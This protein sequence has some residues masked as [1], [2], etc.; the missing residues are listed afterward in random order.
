[1]EMEMTMRQATPPAPPSPEPRTGAPGTALRALLRRLRGDPAPPPIGVD[2]AGERLNLLQ[3]SGA[4]GGAQVR[5]AASLTYPMPRER[6]FDAPP[7]LARFVRASLASAPFAGRRVYCA[8]P[9]GLVRIV[10]LTLQLTPGQSEAQLVAK[11]AREQLG[12]VMDESVLDYY[13][14]RSIDGDAS[15]RHLL[16]A[17]A[18]Q[19]QVMAYLTLLSNAGLE[20]V[21]L[22]IGPAAIARLLAAIQRDDLGQSAL[23]INFGLCKSFLT[24]IWGRR[25]MLDREIDFGE[26]QLGAKLASALAL[27][28]GMAVAL[29]REHGFGA[30]LPGLGARD[31][32]QPDA[33]RTIGDILHPEFAA[34][35]EELARTQVYVAS[36][37]RGRAV[38]RVYLNGS[39]ARYPNIRQRISDLVT[40]P[41]ELLNP[42]DGFA[43]PRIARP[44]GLEQSIAL[45]AGLALRGG[46]GG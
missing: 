24:V 16:L 5:A 25:L 27:A 21:A 1:M 18:R 6:L 41:V 29:M 42:F 8:L 20:P 36:R 45:A 32:A 14:V 26:G 13:P 19:A 39:L 33:G 40:L 2:F 12:I 34:L 37:T 23:L 4:P 28:P 43:A 38:S 30:R 22:D 11:A 44:P 46:A 9:P 35:A 3:M 7:A 31:A 15:E 10:P 17:V